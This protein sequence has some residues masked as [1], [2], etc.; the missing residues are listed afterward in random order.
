MTVAKA[1]ERV[2]RAAMKWNRSVRMCGWRDESAT[3]RI[4]L[5]KA[6]NNL[7]RLAKRRGKR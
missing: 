4:A 1:K 2:V 7:S 6:C 5:E 3:C